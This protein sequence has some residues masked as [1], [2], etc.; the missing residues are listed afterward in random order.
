MKSIFSPGGLIVS[1]LLLTSCYS[2]PIKKYARQEL[3]DGWYLQSADSVGMDGGAISSSGY[4]MKNW[5]EARVPETVLHCLVRHGVYT[6]I[7]RNDNLEKIPQKTFRSPWWYR[8]VF[9]LEEVPEGLLLKFKGINY[10]ANIWLNGRKIADTAQVVNSFRQFT[11]DI[12]P[13]AVKGDNVLA[14]E[15]IPP[16]PG[17]FSI[18]FVDWNPRPP[19]GNMGLFRPVFLEKN[20]GVSVSDP[21]VASDVSDDLSHATLTASVRVKNLSGKPLRGEMVFS[22]DGKD[23]PKPVYLKAGESRKICFEAGDFAALKVDHPRLW[24]PHTLGEPALYQGKF[25][26]RKGRYVLDEKDLHFGI[27]EVTSSLTGEGYRLFRINGR[28]IQIHGA[29]WTDRMLMDD[30]P[31]SIRAQLAYVRDVNLNTIRMEGFWGTGQEIYNLCDSMGILIMVGWSCHW[32]WPEYLGK[33]TDPKYGGILSKED[34]SLMSEAWKDQVVWLRNHPAIFTWLVGSDLKPKPELEKKYR[35]IFQE[36]DTTRDYLAS[37]KA[38]VTLAGPTGVKM[39]GPYAY[40]PPVYWYSD[41]I[42]GGAY[43][44]ATEIGPGAQIP[45]LESL[46]KMFSPDHLWPM[47]DMWMYHSGRGAFHSLNRYMKALQAR[48]G[49]VKDLSDLEK[50]AQAMNYELMRPMFEAYSARRYHATG[51]ILW[52]LNSAW[53]EMYWQLYDYYL[54]PNGAY[55]GAKKALR[56]WHAVYDYSLKALYVVNDKPEDKKDCKLKVRIYDLNSE[57]KYEKEIPVDLTANSS[58][59]GLSLT[60][61]GIAPAYFIDVRLYDSSGNEIDNNFYWISRKKDVLNYEDPREPNWLYTPSKQYADLTA[62]NH[63]PQV[64]VSSSMT[65]KTEKDRTLFTVTL[66][67]RS[68]KIAFFVHAAVRDEKSGATIL[69]VLWSDN[70]ISLLPGEKRVLTATIN[71]RSLR[72]KTP[73][74]M[75]GGYNVK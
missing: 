22:F 43:G 49:K 61:A 54:M 2:P 33:H 60:D 1:L 42:K 73:Q 70:Y 18:G 12:S 75:V 64:E 38:M 71:N 72:D 10:K 69:P 23:I 27:R 74:V 32:E 4:D 7:F 53:P 34:M 44:F 8:R 36:Y 58:R 35:E 37:A 67:N 62:L 29:G 5:Y 41:T 50:K 46:K 26:F 31:A 3:G 65:A 45:P 16:R 30:T 9:T 6:D 21:F 11:F 56:P 17:D 51:L 28:K 68:D 39:E 48:Y 66:Q 24:W 20:G 40:V 14:V 52:M 57:K 25:F 55:Y 59:K 13:Y 63:L 15:V 47:D 19:D